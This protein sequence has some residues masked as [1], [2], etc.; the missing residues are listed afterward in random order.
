MPTLQQRIDKAE[1]DTDKAEGKLMQRVKK[2]MLAEALLRDARCTELNAR[3]DL[4]DAR[5]HLLRLQVS[6]EIIRRTS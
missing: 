1:R 2:T 5:F 4:T 6:E 3:E